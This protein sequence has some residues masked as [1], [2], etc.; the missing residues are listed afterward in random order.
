MSVL[1]TEEVRRLYDRIAGSYD[2]LTLGF[3]AL[4]FGRHQ[5]RLI[6]A[7]TL[8]QGDTVVDLC[9]GTGINLEPLS[10]AVGP[11]GRVIGVDLSEGMLGKARD[12]AAKAGLG[13]IEFIQADVQEYDVPT[14]ASAVLSTFGLEIVPGYDDVVKR[15]AAALPAGGRIGL[16][17]LKHPESWPDWLIKAGVVITAPFGVSREYEDFKPWVSGDTY[18]MRQT[19]TEHLAGAAYTY[20]G[21][22]GLRRVGTPS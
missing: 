1:N 14:S 6:E 13:N 18:F 5:K 21:E 11:S 20:V 12:R 4:G 10:E 15:S 22:A 16:M 17:G 3:R 8:S 7:L 19:F 9:C 2:V